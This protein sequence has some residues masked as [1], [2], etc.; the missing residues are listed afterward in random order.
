MN[1]QLI[2]KFPNQKAYKNHLCIFLLPPSEKELER[3][4][5]ERASD[6]DEAILKRLKR[7]EFEISSSKDFDFLVIN[8]NLDKTVNKILKIID[9]LD[10][11]N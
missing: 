1:N 6:T 10:E 7:A 9:D 11:S 5:R 4:I 3:R 2:L 8:Q